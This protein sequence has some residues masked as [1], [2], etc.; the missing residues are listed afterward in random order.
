[1]IGH[2]HTHTHMKPALEAEIKATTA[3][4]SLLWLSPPIWGEAAERWRDAMKS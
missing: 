3:S 4:H 2:T 1:M